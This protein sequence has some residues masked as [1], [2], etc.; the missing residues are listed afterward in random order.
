[1][2]GTHEDQF[3]VVRNPVPAGNSPRIKTQKCD[4]FSRTNDPRTRGERP[5]KSLRMVRDRPANGP[6][7]RFNAE[8]ISLTRE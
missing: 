8:K 5:E 4:D 6:E 1:M 7:I 2:T 3:C